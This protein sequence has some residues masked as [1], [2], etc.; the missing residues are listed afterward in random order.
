LIGREKSE[1]ISN[2][3]VIVVGPARIRIA[4]QAGNDASVEKLVSGNKRGQPTVPLSAGLGIDWRWS[5]SQA[6]IVRF[7]AFVE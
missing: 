2:L 5:P 4:L 6:L 7:V 3:S 1:W